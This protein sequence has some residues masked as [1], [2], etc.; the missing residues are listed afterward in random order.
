MHEID[1]FALALTKVPTIRL[2]TTLVR[3]V[4]H[5][6]LSSHTPVD[7]LMTSGKPNRFN[8]ADIECVCFS[9]DEATANEEFERPWRGLRAA[10]QPKVTFFAD[11]RL[12]R[13]LDLTQAPI[14]KALKISSSRTHSV[15]EQMDYELQPREF[16][17]LRKG[18][19]GSA[20]QQMRLL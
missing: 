13:V 6:N 14:L 17:T 11:V 3:I 15:S 12:D 10:R 9:E 5:E 18:G 8:P 7:F 1:D 16:T 4:T 19:R 20:F 2:R